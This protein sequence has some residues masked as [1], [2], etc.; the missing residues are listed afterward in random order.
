MN[1]S[2]YKHPKPQV[3]I[4]ELVP[5]L[6]TWLLTFYK[7]KQMLTQWW[8]FINFQYHGVYSRWKYFVHYSTQDK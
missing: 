4:L 2:E 8:L 1:I 3:V 7:N 5:S 6:E